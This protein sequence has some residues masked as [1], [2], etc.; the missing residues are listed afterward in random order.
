MADVA[1]IA[2]PPGTKALGAA[3]TDQ[4]LQIQGN[5]PD[6]NGYTV[7][8]ED[9]SWFAVFGFDSSG[10]VRDND[11]LDADAYLKAFTKQNNVDIEDKRKA[12]LRP[13]YI[14]GWYV[15]PHYDP[16]SHRLEW[17]VRFH[18]DEN[19]T[20]INYS[21]RLL[22]RGGV[23]AATLISEP[24]NFSKD[25]LSFHSMLDHFSFDQG[26]KYA[27]FRQG[28]KLAAYGLGALV[29]GGAA[30]TAVKVGGGAFKAI[31]YAIFAAVAGLFAWIKRFFTRKSK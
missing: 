22:G 29:V 3:D 27:E 25:L 6:P 20:I 19:R 23:M 30:A 12:G 31:G 4:F 26:Q 24:E 5:L 16:Q 13:L 15:V 7:S 1:H 2:L 9:F 28:D 10:Y 14:D 18:D 11:E 21:S 17:G 8:S